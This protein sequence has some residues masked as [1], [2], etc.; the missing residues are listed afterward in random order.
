VPADD[1]TGWRAFDSRGRPVPFSVTMQ[2]ATS[3]TAIEVSQDGTRMLVLGSTD[4]GM[5][6]FVAGIVRSSTGVPLA[7]TTSRYPVTVPASSTP[8]DATWVD[9]SGTSVAVL[10]QDETGDS[11]SEQQLGGLPSALARLSTADTLVG[12][13]APSDLRARLQNGSIAELSGSSWSSDPTAGAD[14]LFVQR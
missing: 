7:L 10:A 3:I 4:R 9:A 6:A 12:G 13:D 14:V 8:L 5:T 11:V 2:D 1:P